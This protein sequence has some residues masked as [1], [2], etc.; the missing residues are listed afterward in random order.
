MFPKP[1]LNPNLLNTKH[2]HTLMLTESNAALEGV[3]LHC[4]S[5]ASDRLKVFKDAEAS[6][7]VSGS[8]V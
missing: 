5:E 7:E 2:A 6:S 4:H 8:R 3:D 1:R